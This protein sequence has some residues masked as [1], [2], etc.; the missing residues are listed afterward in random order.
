M[1]RPLSLLLVAALAGCG[2]ETTAPPADGGLCTAPADESWPPVAGDVTFSVRN[3]RSQPVW[4][5]EP[6]PAAALSSSM[7]ASS[8]YL[9]T[10]NRQLLNVGDLRAAEGRA[11]C[12]CAA[13]GSCPEQVS[14]VAVGPDVYVRSIPAGETVTFT[15]DGHEEL[16]PVTCGAPGEVCF[17]RVGATAGVYRLEVGLYETEPDGFDVPAPDLQVDVEVDLAEATSATAIVP[18]NG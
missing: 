3:E 17:Q 14:S 8:V 11:S 4:Y 2:D 5:L 9:W 16:R 13:G 15:W 18:A 1:H 6:G 12:A 7:D 10:D